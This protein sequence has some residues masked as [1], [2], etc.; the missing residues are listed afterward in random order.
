MAGERHRR[1][2]RGQGAYL[3]LV[4]LEDPCS[5]HRASSLDA[6]SVTEGTFGLEFPWLGLAGLWR[7]PPPYPS[8][9]TIRSQKSFA[10][11]A[12]HATSF[13]FPDGLFQVIGANIE[14]PRIGSP[15]GVHSHHQSRWSS[16]SIVSSQFP[17]HGK[18]TSA[19]H[20]NIHAHG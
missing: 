17:T 20:S 18:R 1:S 15:S 8:S 19:I 12:A 7:R 9:T 6:T 3:Q 16:L 5:R 2:T 4:C 11:T 10:V 13:S 14:I